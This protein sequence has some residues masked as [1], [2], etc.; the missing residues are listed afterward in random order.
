LAKDYWQTPRGNL[1]YD[2]R[3]AAF[4][5]NWGGTNR[6]DLFVAK[7]DPPLGAGSPQQGAPP[8]DAGP[9][10]RPRRVSPH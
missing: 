8:A 5:S 1:S 2:G 4:S 6:V 3:F 9:R 10:R 7:I